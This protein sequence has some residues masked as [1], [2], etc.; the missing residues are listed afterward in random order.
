MPVIPVVGPV[1]LL[2]AAFG[3]HGD[4]AARIAPVLRAV[5]RRKHLQ[6]LHRIH[7]RHAVDAAVGARV[8]IRH[9]VHR[10][11]LLVVAAARDIN[12]ADAGGPRRVAPVAGIHHARHQTHGIEDIPAAQRQRRQF[13]S[14]H[15][16]RLLARHRIQGN[17]VR[18]HRHAFRQTA[19]PHP[20]HAR[21]SLLA[22]IQHDAV[23]PVR[24]KA[25]GCDSQVVRAGI[26]IGKR[27]ES[28]GIGRFLPG[29]ALA[30]VR[31]HHLGCRNGRAARILHNS[32]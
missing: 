18:R 6:F 26:Q 5:I 27:K 16:S 24:A 12:I 19:H 7:R 3:D 4:G 21:A 8:E 20:D 1:K 2:A 13:G 28:L 29:K 32:G 23:L 9:P 22:R 30:F 15:R 25:R 11:I 17:R 10:H 31:D 14:A